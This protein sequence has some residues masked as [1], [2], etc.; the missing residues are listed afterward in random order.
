MSAL[1]NL[2]EIKTTPPPPPSVQ[3]LRKSLPWV[4][5]VSFKCYHI[6]LWWGSEQTVAPNLVPRFLTPCKMVTSYSL[7]ACERQT[8]LL[9]AEG[10]FTRSNVCGSVTEIP[11]WWCKICPEIWSEALIGRR[12]SFIVLAIVYEWQI[13][14]KRRQRSNV[15][16]MNLKQNSQY[17]WNIA[18]AFEFCWSSFTDEHNTFPKS[19]RRNVKSNKFTFGTPWLRDLLCK[20]WFTSSVWNF[21]H[22]VADVPP[23][24][25]SL[26]DDEPVETSPFR[27]LAVLSLSHWWWTSWPGRGWMK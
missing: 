20:Y 21:R 14:D 12:S 16:T 6:R 22:W 15:N 3:P 25:T 7:V 18:E 17:L 9:A 5:R 8:F 1:V 4:E 13:K 2:T 19:T 26:S 10:R 23:R 24:E 27:R 11:Y